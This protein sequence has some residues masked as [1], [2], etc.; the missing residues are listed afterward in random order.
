MKKILFVILSCV[1]AAANAQ[2]VDEVIQKYA[3]AMGG[4]E[5]FK[6]I[7]TA[8]FTGVLTTQGNSL[9]LTTQIINGKAMRTDVNVNGQEV[10]N[11]YNNGKGWK[12]N[13]I[14]GGTTATEATAAELVGF[15]AQAS[16]ANNLMDYQSRG[17]LVELQGKED[18]EGSNTFRIKLTSKD[19]GKVTA[20]F[21]DST[22]YMLLKSITKRVIAGS[23]YD[24]ET[25]YSNIKEI[26]GLKFCMNFIQKIEGKV[27]QSV[28]YEKIELN[29]S[30]DK[31]IF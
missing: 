24:T 29:I 7:A 8:K 14:T 1:F 6:K 13:P 31:K 26:M 22:S 12:I 25:F 20:Y 16:L 23:E 11:A 30:V 27:L 15:K 2:P 21:I 17:H 3:T 28:V 19:D 5:S 4:L 18:V 9:P 10:T